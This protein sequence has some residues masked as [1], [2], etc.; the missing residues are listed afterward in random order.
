MRQS[1]ES[2]QSKYWCKNA[3]D[4]QTASQVRKVIHADSY[5]HD[6]RDE[7]QPRVVTHEY[8]DAMRVPEHH[9]NTLQTSAEISDQQ[10][11]VE[12]SYTST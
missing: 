2:R 6:K 9:A 5:Q 7:A 12:V 3:R 8:A 11:D 4:V 1:A 10:N